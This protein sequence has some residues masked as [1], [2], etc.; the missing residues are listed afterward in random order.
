MRPNLL[1][2]FS[3]L[4]L[5][6]TAADAQDAQP[7][8]WTHESYIED[9]T[10][11]DTL[12]VSYPMKVF[13]F[14]LN[15]LPGEVK[16]YPTENYYYFRFLHHGTPYSGN[17]RIEV[18]DKAPTL[19]FAYYQTETAWHPNE[20]AKT[21]TLGAEQGV[22]LEKKDALLY[23]IAYAGKSVLFALNDL[24]KAK[25]PPSALAPNERFIGPI[26]DESGVRFFLVFN[27]KLK[28]FLY[29]LD[30]TIEPAEE[31]FS[32]DEKSRIFFGRRTG[33]AFFH[34]MKLE[35]KIL[36][37]V[38]EDNLLLNTYFDGPFDQ[39]PD[40]FIEGETLR[41]AILAATPQ[42]NGK[43]DRYGRALD[44]NI[45]YAIKPYA[46]YLDP[47]DLDPIEACARKSEKSANYYTCFDAGKQ[48]QTEKKT[49]RR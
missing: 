27:D 16:V 22:T 14:V 25:P 6:A 28:I 20:N 9:V 29:V 32:R 24:S 17:I 7:R 46:A 33:F 40:N 13:A 45:R 2:V 34:D 18:S 41:S 8:L 42:L 44:R 36:I 35:R 48:Q 19:H 10:R 26:F 21:I 11:A 31:F 49:G 30:E 15:S 1:A 4:A 47:S 38:Y 43:I 5:L 12:D 39:L 37:G 23:R 3:A